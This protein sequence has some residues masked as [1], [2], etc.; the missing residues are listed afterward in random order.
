MAQARELGRYAVRNWHI[1][2]NEIEGGKLKDDSTPL[3]KLLSSD[4]QFGKTS[5]SFPFAVAGEENVSATISF[6]K[7]FATAPLVVVAIEGINVGIVNVSSTTS[8]FTVTVRDDKGIDYTT[9]QTA[10][11]HWIAIRV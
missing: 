8:N 3:A 6:P 10:T 9:S 1:P 5:V 7:A 4:I 11:V 2:S